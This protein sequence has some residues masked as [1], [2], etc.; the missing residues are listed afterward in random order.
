MPLGAK[1]VVPPMMRTYGVRTAEEIR[2]DHGRGWRPLPRDR[3]STI[4]PPTA[5]HPPGVG[6]ALP[7]EVDVMERIVQGLPS[8]LKSYTPPR[9]GEAIAFEGA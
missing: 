8:A 5:G 6:L 2:G 3:P 1:P 9:I 7:G 4:A